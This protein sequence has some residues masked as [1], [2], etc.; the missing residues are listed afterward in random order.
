VASYREGHVKYW[1]EKNWKAV[2]KPIKA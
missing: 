1:D 2:D